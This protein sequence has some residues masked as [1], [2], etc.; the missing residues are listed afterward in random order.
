MNA[1]YS[2]MKKKYESLETMKS[3]PVTDVE[4]FA[5]CGTSIR[6]WEECAWA[7]HNLS[8]ENFETNR[9]RYTKINKTTVNM[10]QVVKY[11][12][13]CM[14]A[15]VVVTRSRVFAKYIGLRRVSI[16][17]MQSMYFVV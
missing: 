12:K 16:K 10:L 5:K 8:V 9:V 1:V 11:L 7:D 3:T 13:Q 4:T 14:S 15:A 6:K 17:K 2:K